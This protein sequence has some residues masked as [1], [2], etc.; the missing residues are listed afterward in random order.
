MGAV[1][2]DRPRGLHRDRGLLRWYY[3]FP[4][5]L[6]LSPLRTFTVAGSAQKKL[7]ARLMEIIYLELERVPVLSQSPSLLSLSYSSFLSLFRPSR[8][9]L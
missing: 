4:F 9:R 5:S 8:L 1:R 6:S 3:C 7:V 2:A